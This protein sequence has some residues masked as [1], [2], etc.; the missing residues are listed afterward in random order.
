MRKLCHALVGAAL[1]CLAF[2]NLSG[3]TKADNTITVNASPAALGTVT[4]GG[5]FPTGSTRTVTATP[6]PTSKFLRW[7]EDSFRVSGKRRY[8]FTLDADRVLTAMFKPRKPKNDLV[9][10]RGAQGLWKLLNETTWKR[11]HTGN[12]TAIAAADLTGDGKEEIIFGLTSPT[13][14]FV[15]TT[16]VANRIHP[17]PATRIVVGDFDADGKDDLVA[18]F[19]GQA[20]TFGR[21]GSGGGF[22]PI[23]TVTSQGLAVGDI[24]GDGFLDIISR[25]GT[26]LFTCYRFQA[27]WMNL[28]FTGGVHV[29][30]G[31]V[32]GDGQADLITGRAS[33]GASQIGVWRSMDNGMTWT[34][35]NNNNPSVLAIGDAD[36]NATDGVFASFPTGLWTSP[37][38][39]TNW[40]R[41]DTSTP[42]A[43][44]V[45]D[46]DNNG[47]DDIVGIFPPGTNLEVRMNNAGA[48]KTMLAPPGP[49]IVP[50]N[51]I[52][53][54]LD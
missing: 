26:G 18:T 47:K 54:A 13:G 4:G 30:A 45:A 32:N 8:T 23:D 5:T 42:T 51:V 27:P 40:V 9:V 44:A 33:G 34:R 35:I 46:F 20:G 14:T 41:I 53:A 16:A 22:F 3:T 17:N 37:N 1:S 11:V 21:F 39:N 29:A 7:D 6:K 10:D 48:F 52:G 50:Q 25:R 24:D 43:I 28:N 19:Q 15:N 38:G 31:D 36:N 49:Q 12:P 2:F